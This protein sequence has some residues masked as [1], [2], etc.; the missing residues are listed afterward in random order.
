VD[1]LWS[2][3]DKARVLLRDT[4]LTQPQLVNI[5]A[6]FGVE[7]S[8]ATLSRALRDGFLA[9]HELDQRV[10]VVVMAL[11]SWA[12]DATPFFKVD[13]SDTRA[14]KALIDLRLSGGMS[15]E[16]NVVIDG[17]DWDDEVSKQ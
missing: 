3:V 16:V 13:F 4:A 17:G 10:R 5:L 14:V 12:R 8:N 1:E 9:K 7:L 2:T 6:E 11:E 15:F